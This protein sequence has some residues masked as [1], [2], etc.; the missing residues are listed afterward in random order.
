MKV[1]FFI[2]DYATYNAGFIRGKWVE[3]SSDVDAMQE[4][5]DK[6]LDENS[7]LLGELCE[8]PMFQDWDD[9]TPGAIF[10]KAF[11]ECPDLDE[12][13]ELWEVLE[14]EDKAPHVF[15]HLENYSSDISG[16][17][18]AGHNQE[19]TDSGEEYDCGTE[20]R[21]KEIMG[22]IELRQWDDEGNELPS[23]LVGSISLACAGTDMYHTTYHGAYNGTLWY[24]Y[25]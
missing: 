9:E 24:K 17:I 1:Q 2:S 5:I 10:R 21:A 15:L 3:V 16:A 6:V 13:A 14:D 23:F 19:W 22:E 11:G 20:N 7:R 4:E 25:Q 8:E 18:E 12:V